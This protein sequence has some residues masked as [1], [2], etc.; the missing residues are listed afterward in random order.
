MIK[1]KET[2]FSNWFGTLKAKAQ[3]HYMKSSVTIRDV[4]EAVG[5]TKATVS[6]VFNGKGN[7]S[8]ATTEAVFQA[9]RQLNFQPNPHAQSL[10]NGGSSNTIALLFLHMDLGVSVR[11]L[12][13]IQ[14][15]LAHKEYE[16]PAYSFSYGLQ[17]NVSEHAARVM[18]ALRRQHPRAIICTPRGLEKGALAELAR[19]QEQG[20]IVVCYDT[21]T[22]V[23][24]DKVVFDRQHST[25]LATKHLLE[26]GHR[27]IG[28][29]M[30]GAPI[31]SG[32]YL[33]GFHEALREFGLTA[34]SE[35]LFGSEA[36]GVASGLYEEA[37]AQLA[38]EFLRLRK[39]PTA[40]CIAD[41]YAAMAFATAISEAGFSVPEE[42]SVIG[43]DDSPIARFAPLKLSTVTHPTEIIASHVVD[44]ALSRID[45]G[46][47]AA[48]REV[49]VQGELKLRQSTAKPN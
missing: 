20:G 40:M 23:K 30:P 29:N 27:D 32:S 42:V 35:W 15:L 7:I 31:P 36:C 26:L 1:F 2:G 34:K 24:C 22:D 9:A 28:F 21:P 14:S 41:D 38:Q 37:G 5:V 13:T 11:K 33:Q 48:F 10:S 44:L 16:T 43:H 25:Y 39:R 49:K 46:D 17:S 47:V 8:K 45:N 6:K 18:S 4:A 3:K 19:Y 12:Q